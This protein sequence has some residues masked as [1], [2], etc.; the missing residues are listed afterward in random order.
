MSKKEKGKSNP[1]VKAQ[2]RFELINGV[3]VMV[4]P[5][6][7]PEFQEDNTPE[8]LIDKKDGIISIHTEETFLE[9]EI[10][11]VYNEETAE[12]S[13]LLAEKVRQENFE[14]AKAATQE[15]KIS[16][17]GDVILAGSDT[18]DDINEVLLRTDKK[19]DA[20]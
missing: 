15:I 13:H 10:Q 16:K 9:D 14:R 1:Q 12:K 19:L 8:V 6:E 2:A 7:E 18:Y 20:N 11:Y 4:S 17:T 3:V 5:D